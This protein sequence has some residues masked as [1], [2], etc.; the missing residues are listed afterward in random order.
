M[1]EYITLPKRCKNITGQR[2]GRWIALGPVASINNR[3]HWLCQC[4]C[5]NT[6]SIC[7][8]VLA[9]GESKSCGCLQKEIVAERS[10]THGMHNHPLYRTWNGMLNRCHNPKTPSY[11]W[12]GARGIQVY[13]EW[14]N[15]FGA[16]A[17]YV[18]ALPDYMDKGRTLDRI[19]NSGNYEPGNLRWATTKGQMRNRRLNN[20]LSYKGETLCLEEWAERIGID[21]DT[22]RARTGKLRWSAKKALETPLRA[23]RRRNQP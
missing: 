20:R 23:D 10:T 8:S 16:F 19:D 4:D 2:F 14:R 15:S 22:L 13:G 7:Y 21:S 11:C 18:C 3:I 5:G 1:T 17:D 6:K 9:K 12:Y